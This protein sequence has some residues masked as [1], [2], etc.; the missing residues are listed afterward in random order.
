MEKLI[1]DSSSDE[2][3]EFMLREY[4]RLNGLRLDELRQSEQR[5]NFF[6]TI[7]SAIGG[8]LVIFGQNQLLS[9]RELFFVIEG[10]LTV[11]FAYG[12]ITLNRLITRSNN[13][14][15]IRK[16]Q[17]RIQ[18]YFAKRSPYVNSYIEFKKVIFSQ[19]E[20][21]FKLSGFRLCSVGSDVLLIVRGTLED[22][23]VFTNSIILTTMIILLLNQI[24]TPVVL[25]IFLFVFSIVLFYLLFKVYF[26]YARRIIPP[27]KL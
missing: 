25:K 8:G 19:E 16:L 11:L 18:D 26:S 13:L 15:A 6:L 23:V 10:T 3:R 21:P 7:S 9:P 5:V 4:E 1:L 14:R 2:E 12:F 27:S 24:K 20:L 17:Y 22:F